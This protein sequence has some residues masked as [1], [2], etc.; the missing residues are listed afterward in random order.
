MIELVSYNI[1]FGK[2]LGKITSWI[3]KAETKPD[4][5]CFQEFPENRVEEFRKAMADISYSCVFAPAFSKKKVFYGELTAY[6]STLRLVRSEVIELGEHK[7]DRAVFRHKSHRSSLIT[8]FKKG[9]K[10]FAVVNVHLVLLAMHKSRKKQLALTISKMNKKMPSLIVGDYNY[11]KVFGRKR[12]LLSFMQEL[13][14]TMAGERV[15]THRIWKIP[16]QIDYAFYK[17]LEV[18]ETKVGRVKYSDHFPILIKFR[19]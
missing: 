8:E 9:N 2:T 15:I 10:T 12:G 14:Y 18:E 5:V 17:D 4:I 19:I 6:R 7:I 13:G 3:K 1:H 11:S 16:Q